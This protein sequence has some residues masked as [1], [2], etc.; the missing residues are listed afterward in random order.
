MASS[1]LKDAETRIVVSGGVSSNAFFLLLTGAQDLHWSPSMSLCSRSH[2]K[3]PMFSGTRVLI[4]FPW[5]ASWLL[6]DFRSGPFFPLSEKEAFLF[7]A[8]LG[9]PCINVSTRQA[10]S[11]A[12]FV[13]L[14]ALE[15][16]WHNGY[17]I[18]WFHFF[19]F[20]SCQW[21]LLPPMVFLSKCPENPERKK[22]SDVP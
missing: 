5:E 4:C 14:Y 11:W 6:K 3:W 1:C 18:T 2:W 10:F 20:V 9:P 8:R 16:F 13:S 12:Q 19:L 17:F 15:H 7:F 21:Y 22:H